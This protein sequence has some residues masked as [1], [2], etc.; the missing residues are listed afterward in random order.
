MLPQFVDRQKEL[1][2]LETLYKRDG[3]NLVVIYGRRRVGKT[4]LITRPEMEPS[5]GFTFIIL[6]II[7]GTLILLLIIKLKKIFLWKAWY[8]IAVA[9][10]LS[11]AF[12][13]FIPTIPAIIIGIGLA[14]LK[15]LRPSIII[16]NATELFIY[17]GLI[18][19]FAPI[20]NLKW[21]AILL[22]AIS[23]YD[24]Y[25]VW[26]SEHMIKLA[27][28]QSKA[29]MFAGFFIPYSAPKILK[30]I[31]KKNSKRQKTR[32]TKIKAA[33]IGGGDIGFTL[34]FA[35][36]IMKEIGFLQAAIT[37][38][39]ATI[40]LALLLF[41]GKK[42][43]FYPAMPFLTIGCFLGYLVSIIVL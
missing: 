41:L 19:I 25:A 13:A 12:N 40:A 39:S 29:K 11:I 4:E 33:V 30:P 43:R 15:I 35:S 37:A 6:A 21:A 22:L 14:L 20:F 34:L 2:F 18:A 8:F 7:I 17:G 28:A 23:A 31:E 16:H 32:K 42:D 3:F 1:Q 24:A 27:K 38:L 5:G 36:T 26:K 10:C 9:S